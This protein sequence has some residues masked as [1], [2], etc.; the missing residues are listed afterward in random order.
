MTQKLTVLEL[1]T[2][3]QRISQAIRNAIPEMEIFNEGTALMGQPESEINFK[4]GEHSFDLF[5]KSDD[6]P[7]SDIDKKNSDQL[8]LLEYQHLIQKQL[9]K[10]REEQAR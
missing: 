8:S 4:I 9:E 5:L 1:V 10:E 2:V 6:C 7:A 3:R